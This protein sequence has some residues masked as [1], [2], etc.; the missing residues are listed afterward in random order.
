VRRI[1]LL[2]QRPQSVPSCCSPRR[3]H[4]RALLHDVAS[5]LIL[6]HPIS[7]FLLSTVSCLI[8][9][10]FIASYF[11]LSHPISS[12]LVLSPLDCAL[13]LQ[14]SPLVCVLSVLQRTGGRRRGPDQGVQ[15]LQRLLLRRKHAPAAAT[16]A[17]AAAGVGIMPS[18]RR[19]W[20]NECTAPLTRGAW[21]LLARVQLPLWRGADG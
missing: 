17:T 15:R 11:I 16:A 21:S 5:Y 3:L 19:W 9:S 4:P 10:H 20:P 14:Y 1:L 7:S 12:Y 2:P 18:E 13:S 6:S 8:L